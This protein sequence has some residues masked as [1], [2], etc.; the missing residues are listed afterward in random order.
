[1]CKLAFACVS[2]FGLGCVFLLYPCG[3]GEIGLR[4]RQKKQIERMIVVQRETDL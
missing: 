4:E 3:S 1:M 2:V